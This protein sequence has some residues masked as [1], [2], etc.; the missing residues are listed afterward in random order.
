[1]AYYRECPLCGSH[2]DPGEKCECREERQKPKSKIRLITPSVKE[3]EDGQLI[4]KERA[5]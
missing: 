4:W 3:E 2:L 5:S 1:M